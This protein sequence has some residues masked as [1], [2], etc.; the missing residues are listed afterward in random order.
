MFESLPTTILIA[1]LAAIALAAYRRLSRDHP[2]PIRSIESSELSQGMSLL[3]IICVTASAAVPMALYALFGSQ[4]PLAP[5]VPLTDSISF[6]PLFLAYVL[7]CVATAFYEESIFRVIAQGLFERGF[8]GNGVRRKRCMLYAAL[9]T[10]A[11]FAAMHT[12]C[13]V[14]P[15]ADQ[16]QV[17]MQAVFKCVQGF[18]FGIVMVGL[19]KRTGSLA[20]VVAM[21]ACYNLL[22]F[23]PWLL[24]TGSFPVSYLTGDPIDSAGL[25]G[26][27]VWLVPV[28]LAAMRFLAYGGEVQ[29]RFE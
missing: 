18:L 21:H 23:L 29:Q 1:V 12:V 17:T 13:P 8:A 15:D 24:M 26:T 20:L 19:L 27:S 10:S 7:I 6:V 5:E 22:F 2:S 9:L 16:V 28:A 25:V 3:I 14:P 4:H 11:L